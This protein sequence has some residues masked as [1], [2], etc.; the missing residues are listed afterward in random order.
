MTHF[1][2]DPFPSNPALLSVP[3]PRLSFAQRVTAT[4]DHWR[5]RARMRRAL[6]Q[7][8]ARCLRDA[9]IVPTQAMFEANQ[10]FW[11]RPGPL[12]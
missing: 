11:R 12:R 4:L 3:A 5:E 1:S 2:R 7:V 10:P 9:G 8:D 6:A